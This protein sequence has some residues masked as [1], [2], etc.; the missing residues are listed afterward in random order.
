M[1]EK[2]AVRTREKWVDDV[3]VIACILVVLGHFFQSMTKASILPASDLYKWF[4][5]TI[6]YFHVPLFFIC[7]GYLYQKYSKVNSVGSWCKNVTKKALALGVPY[8]TFT[9]ATWVLKKVFSSSVNNQIGGLGDTLIF[10]PASPYWYL[11]A[12]FFIFLLTPTFKSVKMAVGGLVV[13]I[14]MKTIALSVGG[15]TAFTQYQQFS[16]TKSGLCSV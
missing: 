12:L 16:Q 7:S 4:N 8:A 10:H 9:T 5:T 1:S 2:T 3:K 15:G 14:A 13:A 11:Y 6:Y